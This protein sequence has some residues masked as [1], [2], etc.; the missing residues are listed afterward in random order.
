M[1]AAPAPARLEWQR[2]VL[3]AATQNPFTGQQ[4]IYGW[5][6]PATYLEGSVSLPPMLYTGANGAAWRL[7]L[8][9]TSGLICVFQFPS[10]LWSIF[11][12][13]LSTDGGT[14]GRYFRLKSGSEK[15]SITTGQMYRLV[16]DIREA[17]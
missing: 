10:A 3:T 7:F 15:W 11:P 14:T 9:Q 5:G 4:Q 8:I 16:F 13:E 2:N 12:D 6:A 17:L 1:P